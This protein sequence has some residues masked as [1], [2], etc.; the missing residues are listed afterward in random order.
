[1]S[2][3]KK[4]L[5][6]ERD[7]F[8][9]VKVRD[10]LQHLGYET[11]VARGAEDFARKLAADAPALAL[12]H[13]GLAG[14]DWEQAIAGAKAVQVPTLAFGSHV[15]LEAQQAARR[16]GADRVISNSKLA[17]DLPAIVARM[18]NVGGVDMP[19]EAE[20]EDSEEEE[21]NS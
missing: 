3:T 4:I 1:M 19:E 7:L 8:F 16:A 12:V 9:I 10:T 17:K 21:A 5:L 6:L 20:D 11:Q 2:E 15:D 13:T 18:V 14:V